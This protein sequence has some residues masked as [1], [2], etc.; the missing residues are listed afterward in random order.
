LTI[1]TNA[2]KLVEGNFLEH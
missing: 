2:P 1:F